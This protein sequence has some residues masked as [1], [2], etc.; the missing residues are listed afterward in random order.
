MDVLVIYQYCT[1]GGVERLIL[2]RAT[3]FMKHRYNIITH[4]GYL[5]DS[6]A[7]NSFKNYILKNNLQ[8]IIL[9][10]LIP[11]NYSIIN[12]NYDLI[13][14]IDTPEILVRMSSFDNVFIECHSAYI[15]N[16]QYLSS[17]P[18]EIRGIIVPSLSFKAIIQEEFP[19]LRSLIVLPNPVP[20][21]F[22]TIK[23]NPISFN[24]RPLI[25]LARLDNLKNYEEAVQ[26]FKLFK[27]RQDI[28]YIVV[29]EGATD[30]KVITTFEQLGLIENSILRDKMNFDQ[31]PQLISLV[32]KA[33][34]IYLSPSKGESFGLSAAEFISGGVPVLLS[35]IPAH[36]ALVANDEHF[37]YEL[38]DVISAKFK[39][40][41]ILENW[42][43]MSFSIAEHG[44]KFKDEKFIDAWKLF[45][46][47]ERL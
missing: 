38:N 42:E 33:N 14:I 23:S 20:N 2:N 8:D 21:E 5:S 30:S 17:I 44:E 35:N 25:Y 11:N 3:A 26:I 24:K 31:I 36:N 32:K 6:G 37:L 12:A 34:G 4:V 47:S 46:I 15:E 13:L 41:K 19:N 28:M 43:S 18:K 1:F 45:V 9:P 39:I 27:D 22:H 10:F 16:R 7:L 40:E 29:G